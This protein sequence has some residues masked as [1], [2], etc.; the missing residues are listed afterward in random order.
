MRTDRTRTTSAVIAA[1]EELVGAAAAVADD[2]CGRAALAAV[3]RSMESSAESSLGTTAGDPLV[4]LQRRL[5]RAHRLLAVDPSA[6]LTPGELR[7]H[8]ATL[9]EPAPVPP[10]THP[11][12]VGDPVADGVPVAC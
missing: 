2:A 12:R 8:L 4:V 6:T 10:R 11:A 1:L 3:V 5:G 7:R 9:S